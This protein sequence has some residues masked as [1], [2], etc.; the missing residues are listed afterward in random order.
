MSSPHKHH[1]KSLRSIENRARKGN[2]L[3]MF[4]LFTF[5][6]KGKYVE[7]PDEK[8]AQQYLNSL[9]K[10]LSTCL[11][12]LESLRLHQFRRIQYID[13]DFHPHLTVIIG[14][15]GVG[16]TSVADAIAKS[17]SWFN[18]NLE[19]DTSGRPV[20]EH[21]INVNAKDYCEI[22][23]RINIGT[24][25][26]FDVVLA[27]TVAGSINTKSSELSNIKSA[28]QIY[29]HFSLNDEIILPLLA[30]YSVERSS[31]D[32]SYSFS[33]NAVA[34]LPDNRYKSL[35]DAL[36]GSGKLS[37]F[38][39]RYVELSNTAHGSDPLTINKIKNLMVDKAKELFPLD[40]SKRL[41]DRDEEEIKSLIDRLVSDERFSDKGTQQ[42]NVGMERLVAVN[43]AIEQVVPDVTNLEVDRSSGKVKL[44]VNNFGNRVNVAQLSEGQ[45][46]LMALAGDIAIRLVN[47]NPKSDKPLK[48]HGV[49]IIDEIEL[50]LHPQWQQRVLSNLREVFPNIQFVVTT[51]SPQI[52]NHIDTNHA[53]VI[54][55]DSNGENG[56]IERVLVRE[57]YGKNTDLIYEG[58][59]GVKSRPEIVQNK[60]DEIFALIGRREVED[61]K[62]K[63]ICLRAT[64]GEDAELLK[65]ET[66]LKR[67]ELIGR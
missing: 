55:L 64:I 52:L 40:S 11:L 13:I 29:R 54:K 59:M 50:H 19:R 36:E 67:L 46:T 41:N 37:K 16:K 6:K 1:S 57:T 12:K 47:L 25:T 53:T 39:Q 15:N 42:E 61:A 10:S 35:D 24:K 30:F 43:A 20:T 44:M 21:D 28:A 63:I 7:K 27:R 45:K 26:S 58:N 9:F 8:T 62:A 56:E 18:N 49:V 33:E 14:N 4:E 3:S 17:F 48:A 31:F 23:T 66:L 5:Y 34:D 22:V 2:L 38:S 65:A 51:H 60:L 32:L